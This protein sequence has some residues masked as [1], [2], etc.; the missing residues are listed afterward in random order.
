MAH[1]ASVLRFDPVDE[2]CDGP[3]CPQRISTTPHQA[4]AVAI[5]ATVSTDTIRATSSNAP[6]QILATCFGPAAYFRTDIAT[7]YRIDGDQLRLARDGCEEL[8]LVAEPAR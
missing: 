1:G 6:S 7:R 2:A 5:A 3:F 8:R 4:L